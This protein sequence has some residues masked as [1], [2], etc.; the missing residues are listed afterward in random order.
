MLRKK[1]FTLIELLVVISIIGILIGLLLP[2]VQKVRESASR[3]QCSNN[4][5]QLGLATHNFATTFDGKLP[6][7]THEV[8][9]GS[10]GSVMVALLPYLEQENLYKQY[11]NPANMAP[12][13]A[14][15][16]IIPPTKY[17]ALVIKTPFICPS[18]Y[19][20]SDGKAP[21]GWA[22]TTYTGNAFIFAVLG[23]FTADDPRKSNYKIST[24]PDGLSNTVAF[25][26]KMIDATTSNNRDM[27]YIKGQVN[28][29]NGIY[30]ESHNFPALGMY[31]NTYP[32][33][34]DDNPAWWWYRK[35]YTF[36][37]KPK[38]GSGS[39]YG[40]NSGHDG[41]IQLGIMDGS[42]RTFTEKTKDL[43]VWQAFIPNDGLVIPADWNN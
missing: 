40:L 1:A 2:A 13:S 7:I 5:K 38:K 27:A 18:D 35:S 11:L 34:W 29:A 14:W 32:Y 3:I 25:G 28:P 19:S 42:V 8:A 26:E 4:L 33:C 31:Q 24:V 17:N 39:F 30:T 23:W 6:T 20:S 15:T 36:Y 37:F 22:G 41:V 43:T 21:S 10:E 12:P 9:P 16:I